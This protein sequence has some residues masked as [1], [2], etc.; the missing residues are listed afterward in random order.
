MNESKKLVFFGTED[1]STA[2]LH[3]LILSNQLAA[4]IT[5]PDS[6]AG[7]G[8]KVREP[9][10]KTMAKKAG[11]K[12]FQ[13]KKPIDIRAELIK[14]RPTHG[15]LSAYG[16][17]L[18]QE[19]IDIFPGGIINIHPSLLPKYRGPSPVETAILN[20]DEQTGVSL[21]RLAAG[22]DE[23]PIY[24]QKKVAIP[25][26]YDAS[27]FGRYIAQVGA[28]L[29]MEKL[30]QILDG[31][32]EPVPQD[33]SKAT[34][35]RLLKKDDGVMRFNKSAQELERQVR[36]FIKWPKSRA[37]IFGHEVIVTKARVAKDGLDGELVMRCHPGW[38]EIKELLAPSGRRMSGGDF[39]RGYKKS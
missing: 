7:R 12:I 34:Y 18:P 14:L 24:I 9:A 30:P 2:V 8:L 13:P 27:L 37:K 20:G 35:C 22:M 4:V 38:L 33:N 26:E 32:L 16:K 6:R 29:L 10:V 25:Q 3:Q 1:F 36:A 15:V 28:D 11:L 17:I 23:G 21:M 5:N 31:S 19:V 39:I